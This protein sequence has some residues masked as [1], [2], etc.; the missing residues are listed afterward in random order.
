MTVYY[1]FSALTHLLLIY[2][3]II[4]MCMSWN[5]Y[6]HHTLCILQI[7]LYDTALSINATGTH[8]ACHTLYISVYICHMHI[9]LHSHDMSLIHCIHPPDISPFQLQTSPYV[10]CSRG[11]VARPP[12]ARPPST[13]PADTG[14]PTH[15]SRRLQY[16]HTHTQLY[17]IVCDGEGQNYG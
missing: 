6:I 4:S 5:V 10:R 2:T 15:T 9:S 3:Y 14:S 7:L 12:P 11:A 8:C 17:I 1:L 16:M 13:G